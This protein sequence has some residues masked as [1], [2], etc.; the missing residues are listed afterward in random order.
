MH[1]QQRF[2]LT[3]LGIL[4]AAVV[5]GCPGTGTGGV[6][7][8]QDT[9]T[10]LDPGDSQGPG[11]GDG[12]GTTVAGALDEFE[13]RFPGCEEPLSGDQWR[14]DV[15]RLVN[16]ERTS[17]GLDPVQ[18]DARLAEQ[19][20]QYACEMIFYEFFAHDNPVTGSSLADRAEEF[21][22]D[23]WVVGENLAAGQR[24]PEEVV[25]AWMDSPGHRDNILNPAYTELGVGVRVGGPYRIY[26][27]QEFG[28]PIEDGPF[29]R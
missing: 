20:T 18:Q 15:L 24:T 7:I 17:R 16:V 12:G 10:T 22:Y 9:D 21:N 2:W 4:L 13:V 25:Q 8:P 5:G 11:G 28:R 6:R 29:G 1:Q 27:V 26:W 3:G 23:Y 14:A 19:A